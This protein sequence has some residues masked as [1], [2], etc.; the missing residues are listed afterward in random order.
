MLPAVPGAVSDL[1]L[2]WLMASLALSVACSG[3]DAAEFSHVTGT[4]AGSPNRGCALA[5]ARLDEC[6]I[7]N[8][9]VAECDPNRPE[10]LCQAA[11]LA[12][13]SC[14]ELTELER[15]PNDVSLAVLRCALGCLDPSLLFECADGTQTIYAVWVCD[16]EV[17]C[18]DGSDEADCGPPADSFDCADG[19]DTVP[20]AWVCD[21]TRD[22]LDGSDEVGC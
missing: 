14:E 13:A 2:R 12:E 16:G 5:A 21:G 15:R 17:D 11:C 18:A 4:D 20:G 22:C 10:D 1:E 19:S 6:G 3:S 9:I 8:N 7:A